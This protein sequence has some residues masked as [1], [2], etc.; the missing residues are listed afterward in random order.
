MDF[1]DR[2]PLL[3]LD[4]NTETSLLWSSR[5]Q[6]SKLLLRLHNTNIILEFSGCC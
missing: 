2:K 5:E 4:I 3:D 1:V 6:N